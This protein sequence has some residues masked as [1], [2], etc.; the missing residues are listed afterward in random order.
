MGCALVVLALIMEE[1]KSSYMEKVCPRCG[2]HLLSQDC[3][4]TCDN[5]NYHYVI[6]DNTLVI[7][8]LL[9]SIISSRSNVLISQIGNMIVDE[10]TQICKVFPIYVYHVQQQGV[11]KKFLI[12]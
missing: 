11:Y 8:T 5:K 3:I 7:Q 10:I 4:C 9:Q 2:T 1:I 6:F 12:N